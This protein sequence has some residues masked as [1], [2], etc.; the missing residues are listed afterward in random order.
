MDILDDLIPN[1]KLIV[2]MFGMASDKYELSHEGVF[3]QKTTF[4]FHIVTF[5]D[6]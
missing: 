1:K 3:E 6:K 2:C 4:C 5:L